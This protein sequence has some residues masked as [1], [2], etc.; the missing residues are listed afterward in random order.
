MN[1][2][3][4]VREQLLEAGI[5]EDELGNWCSDLYVKVTPISEK[6]ID[7][8]EFKCNVTKF[9]CNIDKELWYDI[10]FAYTEYHTKRRVS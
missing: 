6:F 7:N 1:K 4:T 3:L 5:K 9:I 8:Y 10:P 2:D